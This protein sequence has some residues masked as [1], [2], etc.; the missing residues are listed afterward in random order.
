MNQQIVQEIGVDKTHS[1]RELRSDYSKELIHIVRRTRTV[2]II[3]SYIFPADP[4]EFILP[5]LATKKER[6]TPGVAL[7]VHTRVY[8][9]NNTL[10]TYLYIFLNSRWNDN[11]YNP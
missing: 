5:L 8:K 2:I 6:H 9:Y 10:Y 3:L 11:N 4:H 7:G 1:S